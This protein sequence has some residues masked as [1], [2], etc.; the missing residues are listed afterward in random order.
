MIAARIAAFSPLLRF[1]EGR[2]GLP[3]CAAYSA[4]AEAIDQKRNTS[5]TL[6][7]VAAA[8]HGTYGAS[9]SVHLLVLPIP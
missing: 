1:L 2:Q 6:A 9:Q 3:L 7:D 4:V 8:R 5:E